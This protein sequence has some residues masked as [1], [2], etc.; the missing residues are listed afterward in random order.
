M[1]TRTARSESN[2][3]WAIFRSGEEPRWGEV[4]RLGEVLMLARPWRPRPTRLRLSWDFSETL[5]PSA[6]RDE[7]GIAANAA[8]VLRIQQVVEALQLRRAVVAWPRRHAEPPEDRSNDH[9]A[10]RARHLAEVAD[11]AGKTAVAK[12]VELD[13]RRVEHRQRL[14]AAGQPL[15]D[16]GERRR[17]AQVADDGNDAVL[18]LEPADEL[19]RLLRGEEVR[20][21]SRRIGVEQEIAIRRIVVLRRTAGALELQRQSRLGEP[22]VERRDRPEVVARER[23]PESLDHLIHSRVDRGR[24]AGAVVVD[25]ARQP[26]D[27]RGAPRLDRRRHGPAEQQRQVFD[28]RVRLLE[29]RLEEQMQQQVVPPDVDDER[30]G[31]PALGDVGEVLIRA[32]ADVGAAAK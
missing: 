10:W 24:V 20:L 8:G 12:Q 11:E 32:D 18:H 4:A 30:D 15:A 6:R 2:D 27:G 21:P 25:V 13:V 1:H 28:A 26:F 7:I 31:R 9:A 29:Q 22:L 14:A 19:E 3:A 5:A 17:T 23:H 16:R